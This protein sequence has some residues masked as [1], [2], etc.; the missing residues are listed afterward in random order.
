MTRWKSYYGVN[1]R[2][3]LMRELNGWIRY[4]L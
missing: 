3:S 1:Q 2:P 4:W